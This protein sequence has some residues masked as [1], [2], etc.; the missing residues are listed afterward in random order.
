[1]G[2]NLARWALECCQAAAYCEAGDLRV[3]MMADKNKILPYCSIVAGV[4]SEMAVLPE[5]H[6][7][8]SDLTQA[9]AWAPIWR[10]GRWN[11]AR[12]LHIARLGA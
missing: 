3:Q 6:Q 9:S 7:Q 2:D 12:L 4:T 10:D 1:M 11:A 5:A 8:M